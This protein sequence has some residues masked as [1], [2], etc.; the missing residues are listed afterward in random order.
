MLS[1]LAF[2][3]PNY[4]ISYFKLL[5]DKNRNNFNDECDGLIYYFEDTYIGVCFIKFIK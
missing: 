5:I 3:T 4:V 1:A 2:V